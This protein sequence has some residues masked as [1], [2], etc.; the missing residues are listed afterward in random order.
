MNNMLKY[1][2]INFFLIYN[3]RIEYIKYIRGMIKNFII[4]NKS[5]LFILLF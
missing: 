1:R 3:L 4:T 2:Y 5:F